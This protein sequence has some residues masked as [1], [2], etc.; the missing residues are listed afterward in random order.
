MQHTNMLK[1][2]FCALGVGG[3][4][5]HG[6]TSKFFKEMQQ[7]ELCH[8]EN[9]FFFPTSNFLWKHRTVILLFFLIMRNSIVPNFCKSF[10]L[11]KSCVKMW[12][13]LQMYFQFPVSGKIFLYSILIFSAFSSMVA[14]KCH[15]VVPY[16][17]TNIY[18]LMPLTVMVLLCLNTAATVCD[19][20]CPLGCSADWAV[21]LVCDNARKTFCHVPPFAR[22]W[23]M[24]NNQLPQDQFFF[25]FF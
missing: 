8:C 12:L 13:P 9:S 18:S 5:K 14:I 2:F 22:V 6:K 16:W 20:L 3:K 11:W 25:S 10:A 19:S 23:Y 24:I 7:Q 4:E 17:V 21:V 1:R 15:A